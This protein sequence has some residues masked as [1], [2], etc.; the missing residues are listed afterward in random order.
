MITQSELITLSGLTHKEI[1]LLCCGRKWERVFAWLCAMKKALAEYSKKKKF[2]D[3]QLNIVGHIAWIETYLWNAY[4]LYQLP[5]FLRNNADYVF[6]PKQYA[7]MKIR[8][9]FDTVM[10]RGYH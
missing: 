3:V 6:K 2:D 4:Y 7:K 1:N 9:E 10:R 8:K 5:G